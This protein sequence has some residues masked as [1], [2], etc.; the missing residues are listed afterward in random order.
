MYGH[1]SVGLVKQAICRIMKT[2]ADLR[3]VTEKQRRE[4]ALKG[5]PHTQDYREIHYERLQNLLL[6]YLDPVSIKNITKKVHQW[7]FFF[8]VRETKSGWKSL[9]QK[10]V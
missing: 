5:T 6:Q 9:K 7:S 1:V 2:R 8:K 4:A 10:M 3:K